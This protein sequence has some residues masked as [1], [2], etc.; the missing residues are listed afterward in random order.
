MQRTKYTLLLVL[1]TIIWGGALVAQSEGAQHL[2]PFTFNV[3]RFSI[4][5]LSLVPA[6]VYMDKKEGILTHLYDKVMIKGGVVCGLVLFCAAACQQ[7]GMKTSRAGTAGF[8]TSLYIVLVPIFSMVI[9]KKPSKNLWVAVFMSVLGMYFL[10]VD[11]EFSIGVGDVWLLGC[12]FFYALHILAVGKYAPKVD[13]LKLSSL[14]FLTC[15]ILGIVP[16]ILEKPTAGAVMDCWLPL[17]Y[18]GLL[19]CG[20]AYTLQMEA[21][22]RVSMTLA[23]VVMSLESVF[24]LLFGMLILKETVTLREAIGCVIML[25]AVL[26][27]EL[28]TKHAPAVLENPVGE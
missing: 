12:A 14:Q 27:A 26:V 23:T 6:F 19:S 8:I 24:T 3:I 13:V 25:A 11:G 15:A 9:G 28:F 21:Q 18:T 10:C 4:G 7:I 2:G 17:C 1:A 20:I 16:M 5:A 22:K